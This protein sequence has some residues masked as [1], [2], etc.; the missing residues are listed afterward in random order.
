M[1]KQDMSLDG[2][3][4]EEALKRGPVRGYAIEKEEGKRPVLRHW[5]KTSGLSTQPNPHALGPKPISQAVIDEMK[6][7]LPP[8]RRRTPQQRYDELVE[9]L[10]AEMRRAKT[11]LGRAAVP[12]SIA[13]QI[14][15]VARTEGPRDLLKRIERAEPE[16]VKI[17]AGFLMRDAAAKQKEKDRHKSALDW[18]GHYNA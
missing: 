17:Y 5:T 9:R 15:H 3:D 2:V 10:L 18:G 7:E 11:F 6:A 8:I 13:A 14:E 16:A 4:A 1:G 12:A